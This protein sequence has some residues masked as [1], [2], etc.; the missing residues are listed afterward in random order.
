MFFSHTQHKKSKKNPKITKIFFQKKKKRFFKKK[1]TQKIEKNSHQLSI[2]SFFHHVKQ[3]NIDK[4]LFAQ[5]QYFDLFFD[6]HKFV[7]KHH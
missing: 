7:S 5:F 3:K 6:I 4:L 1:K 2:E